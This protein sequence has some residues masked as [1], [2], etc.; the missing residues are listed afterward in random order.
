M[1]EREVSVVAQGLSLAALGCDAMGHDEMQEAGQVL[2]RWQAFVPNMLS[3]NCLWDLQMEIFLNQLQMWVWSSGDRDLLRRVGHMEL[4]GRKWWWC[5]GMDEMWF[6]LVIPPGLVRRGGHRGYTVLALLMLETV[7]LC[8]VI[9]SSS[10]QIV[11]VQQGRSFSSP[12]H[13]MS[14]PSSSKFPTVW[15][16]NCQEIIY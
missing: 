10:T 15:F 11:W 5:H 16:L 8:I 9:L 1:R 14:V 4:S 7:C 2:E 12:S 6:R 3:S 13:K